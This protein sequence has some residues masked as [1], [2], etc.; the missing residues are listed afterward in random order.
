LRALAKQS[1]EQQQRKPDC[2]VALLLAMT[3][4]DESGISPREFFARGIIIVVT[5]RREGV[6]T[7]GA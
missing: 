2:F 4:K 7:P 5:L 6:G 1:I 3:A